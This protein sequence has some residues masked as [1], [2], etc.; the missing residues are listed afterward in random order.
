MYNIYVHVPC[1][2]HALEYGKH[3][4]SILI[5][6]IT[7]LSETVIKRSINKERW[8]HNKNGHY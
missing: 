1:R 6:N 3:G 5:P 4:E 8:L 7:G 2:A